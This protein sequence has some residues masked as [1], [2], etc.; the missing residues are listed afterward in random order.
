MEKNIIDGLAGPREKVVIFAEGNADNVTFDNNGLPFKDDTDAM[1][2]TSAR[3]FVEANPQY[4]YIVVVGDGEDQINKAFQDVKNSGFMDDNTRLIVMGHASSL[5]GFGGEDPDKWAEIIRDNKL[6]DRF[7]EVAYGACGQGEYGVCVDLSRAFGKNTTV[8]AQVGQRWGV[9]DTPNMYLNR[10]ESQGYTSELHK[11]PETFQD[12]F[13]TVG[14][15]L[16]TYKGA[17]KEFTPGSTVKADPYRDEI[18]G[19]IAGDIP[20]DARMDPVAYKQYTAQMDS[21]RGQ[22]DYPDYPSFADPEYA[23]QGKQ[24]LNQHYMTKQVE[25]EAQKEF[26][27]EKFPDKDMPGDKYLHGNRDLPVGL[28]MPDAAYYDW[29]DWLDE[30]EFSEEDVQYVNKFVEEGRDEGGN[31]QDD[32]G[33]NWLATE[34]AKRQVEQ[35]TRPPTE[36]EIRVRDENA[37]RESAYRDESTRVSHERSVIEALVRGEASDAG[38]TMPPIEKE[39]YLLDTDKVINFPTIDDMINDPE[40]V[41]SLYVNQDNRMDERITAFK[42]LY[43]DGNQAAENALRVAYDNLDKQGVIDQYKDEAQWGRALDLEALRIYSESDE[44]SF[45]GWDQLLGD[46]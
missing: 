9:A 44:P 22:F 25:Y 19:E 31:I 38:L 39:N 34:I 41:V 4:E 23:Q 33:R 15:G 30:K 11:R 7:S 13:R 28:D 10:M 40:G 29:L 8:Y 27:K 46:Y 35:Y 2:P 45:T 6:R 42:E 21:I 1:F 12:A 32:V 17:D 16:M 26:W 24:T 43:R 14:A 37:A 20:L 18:S 5:G 36:E 3:D